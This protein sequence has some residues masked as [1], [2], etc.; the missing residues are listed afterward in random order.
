[1]EGHLWR[2]SGPTPFSRQGLQQHVAQDHVQLRFE[3]LQR[4]K[5]TTSLGNLSQCSANI[6]NIPPYSHHNEISCISLCVQLPLV[7][8]GTTEQDLALLSLFSPSGICTHG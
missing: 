5:P 2:S 1:M 7:S 6:M 3:Y 4:Q 8:L